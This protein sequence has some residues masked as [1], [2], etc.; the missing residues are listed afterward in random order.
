MVRLSTSCDIDGIVAVWKEAFG[1]SE[2]DIHFFLDAHYSPENTVVYDYNGEIASVLF[3]IDGDMHISGVDYSSY[4]LY[5]ACT[6]KKYRGRGMMSDMLDFSKH[7]ASERNKYFIALKPA[8][9]SLYNYYSRFGYKPVFFKKILSF[10]AKTDSDYF[11]AFIDNNSS[12]NELRNNSYYNYDYFKWSN[13]SVDFAVEHHKYYGGNLICGCKGYILYSVY[14]DV[15]HVKETTFPY[16]E[17]EK[18]VNSLMLDLCIEKVSV[19][20]P[21]DFDFN[22]Y[23]SEITKSG[24]LLPLSEEADI[25]I[26]NINHAYLALTL[27]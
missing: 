16:D 11:Y 3:L 27:D 15:L 24:M 17:F 18:A 21:F 6:L 19:E 8:E 13:D 7:I 10:N 2:K 22:S 26:K 1:D 4:Y 25:I 9:E 14:N 23:N 12:L 5:A 20:L